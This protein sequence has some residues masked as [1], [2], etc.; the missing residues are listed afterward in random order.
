MNAVQLS[1]LSHSLRY[2]YPTFRSS[3]YCGD[4]RSP[5]TPCNKLASEKI[6][7]QT[8]EVKYLGLDLD[9]CLTWKVHVIKKK[10]STLNYAVRSAHC[11]VLVIGRKSPL[12]LETKY[13]S[14]KTI[15]R[16]VWT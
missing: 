15:I 7:P 9:R 12:T 4:Q 10:K 16:S 2:R 8:Q 14:T 6:I 3:S 11:T 1:C 5:T 13:Y